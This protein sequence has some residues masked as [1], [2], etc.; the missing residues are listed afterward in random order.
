MSRK[1]VVHI[2][3]YISLIDLLFFPYFPYI[4][5]PY[6]LPL[7]FIT[8]LF[9]LEKIKLDKTVTIYVLICIFVLLSTL[10]SV[11]INV[12]SEY[13]IDNFKRAMQF[14]TTFVYFFFYKLVFDKYKP[15][16]KPIIIVFSI[17]IFLLITFFFNNPLSYLEFKNGLYSLNA[18]DYG[19]FLFFSRFDYMFKDPNTAGYF[20]L[21][22]LIFALTKL[23]LHTITN[24]LLVFLLL[25]TML[26]TKSVGVTLSV[27][28]FI[29][30][31]IV[32]LLKSKRLSN[33]KFILSIAI[34][35]VI[36]ISLNYKYNLLDLYTVE[37]EN[38]KE[39]IELAEGSAESRVS[40]YTN[41]ISEFY[42]MIF[43]TGYT[44]IKDG[45]TVKPHNDH[46]RIIYSYGLI[47]YIL[48][49]YLLF[50]KIFSSY[51]KIL[52]PAFIAFSFNTLIDEQ[53][54]FA[55]FL[56]IL[57]YIYTE[58]SGKRTLSSRS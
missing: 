51:L 24:F 33:R 21:I 36:L 25:L 20:I 23:N 26:A 16:F 8:A 50:R 37:I 48:I 54:L 38:Y 18:R 2:I 28:L 34:I 32:R 30:L 49:I 55:L 35:T 15:N 53:K 29:F 11:Y 52:I 58:Q 27:I 43:G 40:I 13:I 56:I 1:K 6:S 19:E 17:Y 39:R 31:Y 44:L 3:A 14:L 47:S 41:V 42:P 12:P 4:I 46:L 22:P 7:V 5:M 9:M 57:A 45:V 10:I